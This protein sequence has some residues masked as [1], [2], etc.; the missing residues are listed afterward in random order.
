MSQTTL[1][2]KLGA[3]LANPRWSWGAIRTTDG[4]V[5]LRVWQDRTRR[6]DGA[7]FV[8]VT[9]AERFKDDPD[10]LGYQERL[11]HVERIREG[12][13]CYMVM[14]EAVDVHAVPRAVR[15]FNGDEVF[16]GGRII[17]LDGDWWIE[18]RSRVPVR[19]MLPQ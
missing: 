17:E 12:A 1:F 8:Q 15:D 18:L 13:P 4:A 6:H 9:H 3:P 16:P 19:K 5:F 2:A 11:R 14:C 7:L 10:N